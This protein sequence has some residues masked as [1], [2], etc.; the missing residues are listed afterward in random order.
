MPSKNGKSQ[1]KC[2]LEIIFCRKS[3]ENYF[4]LTNLYSIFPPRSRPPPRL[5]KR[6]IKFE[7]LTVTF[8]VDRQFDLILVDLD[9]FSYHLENIFLEAGQEVGSRCMPS[10]VGDDDLEALFRQGCGT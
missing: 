1:D 7:D 2:Q 10:L 3:E 9:I 5:G 6:N 4:Q 8:S